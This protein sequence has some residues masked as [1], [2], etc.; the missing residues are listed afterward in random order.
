MEKEKDLVVWL[1]WKTRYV[2]AFFWVISHCSC[3]LIYVSILSHRVSCGL[4]SGISHLHISRHTKKKWT[5]E[6][7]YC[8]TNGFAKTFYLDYLISLLF[9]CGSKFFALRLK[10]L[11]TLCRHVPRDDKLF[12][13][14]RLWEG[15]PW[16]WPLFLWSYPDLRIKINRAKKNK[17]KHVCSYYRTANQ[18]LAENLSRL[19][20][21]IWWNDYHIFSLSDYLFWFNLNYP[22]DW[23]WDELERP[24]LYWV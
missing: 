23:L 5:R 21:R 14:R 11:P 22:A 18:L 3:K 16:S 24:I 10:F 20:S 9:I 8:K 4:S 1:C 13:V 19:M 17:R 2:D 6:L 12:P 15:H 7:K